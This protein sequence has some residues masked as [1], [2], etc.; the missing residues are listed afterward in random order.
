MKAKKTQF[1]PQSEAGRTADEKAAKVIHWVSES[2]DISNTEFAVAR[3]FETGVLQDNTKAFLHLLLEEKYPDDRLNLEL[4]PEELRE[5]LKDAFI[6]SY[7]YLFTPQSFIS[8][9]LCFGTDTASI[10]EQMLV[11]LSYFVDYPYFPEM[12]DEWFAIELQS[13]N[14]NVPK[15]ILQKFLGD[16][17]RSIMKYS[18]LEEITEYLHP[19]YEYHGSQ[20]L[21]RKVLEMVL[22][23]K[24]LTIP[25]DNAQE[26]FSDED[27]AFASK[28]AFITSEL[29]GPVEELAPIP[30]YD[31]FLK[32][33][34]DVGVVLPPP[35]HMLHVHDDDDIVL[36]PIQMFINSKLRKK[37]LEKIFHSNVNEY[38]RAISMLNE[39]HDYSQSE[40]N[41]R[42]LLELYKIKPDSKVAIRLNEVLRL[43]F[44]RLPTINS[45]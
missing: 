1:T 25:P 3:V 36:P 30:Q 41:V 23:D 2:E 8:E 22:A 11:R 19:L 10:N 18:S 9:F 7:R 24:N 14:S 33:L 6:N 4:P 32:E 12:L 31:E 16:V 20:L 44:G 34:R 42:S 38:D 17:D 15:S 43:R 29:I 28:E 40:L 45:L 35:H 27:A 13:G 21:G 26:E 37:C 5:L 39:I